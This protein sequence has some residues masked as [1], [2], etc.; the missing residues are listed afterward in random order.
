MLK[1]LGVGLRWDTRQVEVRDMD[2]LV[3]SDHG[4]WQK[5]QVNDLQK[6]NRQWA[7]WWQHRGDFILTLAFPA[8]EGVNLQTVELVEKQL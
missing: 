3:H 8:Q 7:A 1:A 6:E 4:G 2:G 5:M